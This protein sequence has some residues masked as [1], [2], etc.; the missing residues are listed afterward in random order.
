MMKW[1]KNHQILNF[2]WV[3]TKLKQMKFEKEIDRKW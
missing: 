2:I 1:S 3:R